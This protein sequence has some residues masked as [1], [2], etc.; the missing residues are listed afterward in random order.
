MCQIAEGLPTEFDF[1]GTP[2]KEQGP[3][4]E[5]KKKGEEEVVYFPPE[6]VDDPLDDLL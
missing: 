5:N 2:K 4:E 1:V 3:V 6:W